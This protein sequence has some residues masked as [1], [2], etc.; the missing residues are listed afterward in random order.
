MRV[1]NSVRTERAQLSI[2]DNTNLTFALFDNVRVER[3]TTPP[4]FGVLAV[5]ETTPLQI[6]SATLTG[7]GQIKLTLSGPPGSTVTIWRSDD[8][9]NWASIG[10]VSIADG[11]VE[12]TDDVDLSVPQRFYRAQQN[13]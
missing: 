12:F 6:A 8:L 5:P 9:I 3:V 2:S 1:K 11:P 4:G 10:T 13:P 7:G